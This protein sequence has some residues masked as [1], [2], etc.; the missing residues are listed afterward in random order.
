MSTPF[1]LQ[2]ALVD[3]IKALFAGTTFNNADGEDVPLNV[4]P[5]RLPAKK[6]ENDDEHFPYCIVRVNGGGTVS[7]DESPSCKA[8]IFFGLID[9]DPNYQGYKDI[10]NALRKLETHLFSK[11][12]IGRQFSIEYPYDWAVYEEDT[13]PYYFGG[14]ET[15]WT[16]PAVLMEMESDDL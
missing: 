16:L 13:F 3:E 11:R 15:N 12:I 9:E 6:T 14:A 8:L 7:E 5:Q 1:I 10:M 4:Y 2:E